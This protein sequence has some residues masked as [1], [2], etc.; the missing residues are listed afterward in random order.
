MNPFPFEQSPDPRTDDVPRV[1]PYT[2][3]NSKDPVSFNTVSTWTR[4]YVA[5]DEKQR[6]IFIVAASHA[7]E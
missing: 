6:G 1:V 2:W 7:E 3:T 4:G 5:M